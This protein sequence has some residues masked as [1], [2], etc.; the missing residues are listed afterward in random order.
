MGLQKYT[1]GEH[2]GMYAPYDTTQ[3]GLVGV[4]AEST[5]T[6]G[7]MMEDLADDAINTQQGRI[8]D[9]LRDHTTLMRLERVFSR[10]ELSLLVDS[11]STGNE[12]EYSFRV[13]IKGIRDAGQQGRIDFGES[14]A[15]RMLLIG[16]TNRTLDAYA[17][18][19][20][21]GLYPGAADTVDWLRGHSREMLMISGGFKRAL[22]PMAKELGF[23]A[24][25]V[26]ALELDD[27][28]NV[29]PSPLLSTAG[30]RDVFWN[31]LRAIPPNG[32]R[33]MN[34]MIGD[35]VTDAAVSRLHDVGYVATHPNNT[36]R[37]LADINAGP[38]GRVP[39]AV[40]DFFYHDPYSRSRNVVGAEYFGEGYLV[41]VP[42][43]TARS[44]PRLVGRTKGPTAGFKIP[45]YMQGRLFDRAETPADQEVDAEVAAA[46]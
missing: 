23:R 35:G 30:K 12:A 18:R 1:S 26:A 9:K 5:L 36:T 16:V 22:M 43:S 27:T 10:E 38:I 42:G 31:R 32:R 4:D 20:I 7:E 33:Q 17:P 13:L 44:H 40:H 21:E 15:L 8:V 46:R 34:L 25:D 3:L 14:V 24:A 37:R 6:K 45:E 19:Y 39:T 29:L 41:G 11:I 28:G 2:E